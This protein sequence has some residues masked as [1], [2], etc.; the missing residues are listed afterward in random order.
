MK[1]GVSKITITP[2]LK[3]LLLPKVGEI[4]IVTQELDPNRSINTVEIVSSNNILQAALRP[5]TVLKY[6]TSHKME[7]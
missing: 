5:F 7:Q 2:A 1:T 6:K 4:T 3:N